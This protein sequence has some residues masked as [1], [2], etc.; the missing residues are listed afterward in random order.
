[1]S[2]PNIPA[3]KAVQNYRS[4]QTSYHTFSR[5]SSG[6]E[7]LKWL[8][9]RMTPQRGRRNTL[10]LKLIRD[11]LAQLR[12]RRAML[13]TSDLNLNLE[14]LFLDDIKIDKLEDPRV[15]ALVAFYTRL[16]MAIFGGLALVAPMLIMTLHPTR[17]TLLL[18]T[19]SFVFTVGVVL[20]W[21]M[22]TAE[23]KDIIGA[24]AAY[25]AVLVIFVGSGWGF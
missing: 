14:Q 5:Y 24:T 23:P 11:D 4:F 6:Q 12:A 20:A 19:S 1:M 2:R 10:A 16:I 25:A 21:S 8:I 22:D 15:F 7:A 13:R 18:T 9:L 17:L 3:A